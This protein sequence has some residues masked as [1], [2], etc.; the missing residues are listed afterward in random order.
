MSAGDRAFFEQ[1]LTNKAKELTF[2]VSMN[3]TQGRVDAETVRILLE[4]SKVESLTLHNVS[5]NFRENVAV[6]KDFPA[7]KNC[8]HIIH[9]TGEGDIAEDSKLAVIEV[10]QRVAELLKSDRC[11]LSLS[12]RV[13]SG[14][15]NPKTLTEAGLLHAL[16]SNRSLRYLRLCDAGLDAEDIVL[17][18]EALRWNNS[19]ELVDVAKNSIGDKGVITFAQCLKTNSKIRFLLIWLVGATSKGGIALAGSL[20]RNHCLELLHMKDDALGP[21]AGRAF[22][23]MLKVNSSLRYLCLDYCELKTEGCRYFIDALAINKTLSTL[24]LNYNGII[25]RDQADMVRVATQAGVLARLEVADRN[26]LLSSAATN[27]NLVAPYNLLGKSYL[28]HRRGSASFSRKR[29]RSN[30]NMRRVP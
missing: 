25:Q 17:L 14:K 13:N 5:I 4:A 20:R 24:R 15:L 28:W 26:L 10:A 3:C 22:A 29:N 18:C 1:L 27:R 19:I 7:S 2:D 8:A 30:R 16:S 23:S 12:F 21:A 11:L 6:F 9:F